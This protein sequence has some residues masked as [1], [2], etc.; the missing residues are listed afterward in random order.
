MKRNFWDILAWI[1]FF[2][3]VL[4]FILKAMG[5]INSPVS[6]D[7]VTIISAT[8]FFG[9]LVNRFEIL[10][11]GVDIVKGDVSAL[12]NDVG[13]LKENYYS[14]DGRMANVEFYVKKIDRKC[15]LFKA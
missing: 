1:C 11:N 8:Y 6:V 2:E 7:V 4:Y 12:K 15:S 10:E 5:I 13:S 14:L 9:K 3:V